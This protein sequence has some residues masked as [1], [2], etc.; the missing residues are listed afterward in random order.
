MKKQT[1]PTRL[2]ISTRPTVVTTP[3]ISCRGPRGNLNLLEVTLKVWTDG[4]QEV[5]DCS[6]LYSR[7]HECKISYTDIPPGTEFAEAGE[8][9]YDSCPYHT[10]K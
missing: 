6:N 7:S 1:K 5:M 10:K 9:K 3:K 2:T 4:S 8:R